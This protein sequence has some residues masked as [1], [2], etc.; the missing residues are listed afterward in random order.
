M[1]KSLFPI[2]SLC[3]HGVL[4][5]GMM[6]IFILS[7]CQLPAQQPENDSAK[8]AASAPI[9][10]PVEVEHPER[11]DISA[12]LKTFSRVEAERR[13]EVLSQ[14]VGRCTS[15][16]VEENDY[17]SQ[18]QVLA[19]LDK[20]EAEAQVRQNEIQMRQ[21]EVDYV[22][23]KQL[24]EQGF[25][26]RVEFENA[27]FAYEQAQATVDQSKLQLAHHTIRAPIEGLIIKRNVQVGDLVSSGVSLF[28]IIQPDSFMLLIRPAER[29]LPRL[30]EGQMA[31][32]ELD[33]VPGKVFKAQVR[34]I[35][36]TV[37]SD[38]S[39]KVTMDF[40][41]EAKPFLRNDA[42]ARV[43]LVM[44]THENAL[45]V[46]KDSLVNESGREFLYVIDTVS[47]GDEVPAESGEPQYIAKR[48]EV[49]TGLDSDDKVEV[50]SGISDDD[51]IVTMGQH[52]ETLKPGS[53]VKLTNLEREL[54]ARSS[55]SPEDALAAARAKRDSE[56]Q[57]AVAGE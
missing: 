37:D 53:R 35:S 55:L 20:D 52:T 9:V 19:E 7:G 46:P 29:D 17:V 22:R 39:I 31:S 16:L 50:E 23:A 43:L 6:S 45:L 10:V 27:K 57:P 28:T 48:V 33:A 41:T 34:K 44:D 42:Y 51:L 4:F 12:Y 36:P 32:V 8:P 47:P 26:P 49:V 5:T 15:L 24:F 25:S 14:A 56:T 11:G 40:E 3:F 38:G 30:E 54:K 1:R 13:V 18:E 21:R 2:K